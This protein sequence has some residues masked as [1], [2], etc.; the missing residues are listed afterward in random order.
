MGCAEAKGGGVAGFRGWAML[1]GRK[2][3]RERDKTP[4]VF[5]SDCCLFAYEKVKMIF[6]K[7]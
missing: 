5:Q 4:S 3:E 2:E 1:R 7:R 6:C